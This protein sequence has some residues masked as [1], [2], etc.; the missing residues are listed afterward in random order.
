MPISLNPDSVETLPPIYSWIWNR[1][2]TKLPVLQGLTWFRLDVC[3]LQVLRNRNEELSE[4]WIKWRRFE[5]PGPEENSWRVIEQQGLCWSTSPSLTKRRSISTSSSVFEI[6]R[7]RCKTKKPFFSFLDS[8]THPCGQLGTQKLSY[9]TE[10][11]LDPRFSIE[12][13]VDEERRIG[14][15][16]FSNIYNVKE[17]ELTLQS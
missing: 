6:W 7:R 11:Y 12:Y 17:R 5:Q 8:Y 3:S 10:G 13:Y 14:T 9:R 2:S 1:F 16:P 4:P 15:I